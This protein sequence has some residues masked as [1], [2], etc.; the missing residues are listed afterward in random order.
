MENGP[1]KAS[2][3]KYPTVA[4]IATRP[5]IT[6][7]SRYLLTSEVEIPDLQ[8]PMGSKYP[9]GATTPGSP[10]QGFDSSGTHPLIAA[11]DEKIGA[12]VENGEFCISGSP[13]PSAMI[14]SEPSVVSKSLMTD[15]RLLLVG[16]KADAVLAAKTMDETVVNFMLSCFLKYF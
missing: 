12:T 13:L 9:V 16:A 1:L 10:R 3:A 8:N 15:P 7:D 6:S 2:P 11:I 14:G 5:C 4:S